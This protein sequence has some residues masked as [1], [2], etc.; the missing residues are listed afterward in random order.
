METILE[1]KD[2]VS[3]VNDKLGNSKHDALDIQNYINIAYYIGQQWIAIDPKNKQLYVPSKK[4]GE[5]RY[6]ANKVQPIVRT[7]L[8][9]LIKNKPICNVIPFSSEDDDIQAAHLG[10]KI[11]QAMDFQMDL[12]EAD[13]ELIM[14]G[15]CFG[16]SWVKPFWNGS[17]GVDLGGVHE[18]DI[19]KDIISPFELFWDNSAKKWS[20]V[21]WCCHQKTRTVDYVQEVYEKKVAPE[22][23]IS[24]SNI[25]D[26]KIQ[27][28][29]NVSGIEYKQ[30][31]NSVIVKEYWEKPTQKYPKG[32]RITIA[33]ETLLFYIEDIG[34][35]DEDRTERILPFFPFI[36]I[37][38]PGKVAGQSIIENL[39][40]VQRERNKSRS[41]IIKNK[42]LMAYPIWVAE[43]DTLENEII[44][45]AGEII[46]Y[47]EEAKNPPHIE[48]PPS[49]SSDVFESISQCDEE[50]Y[51]I[52]GQ[53]ETS[54]GALP[55]GQKLSG[56]GLSILQEQD[57][58]KLSPTV[59]NF[60]KCKSQYMSYILKIIKFKY[61]LERT[62]KF[63]GQTNQL[64]AVSFKGSDLT[65]TDV[66]VVAGS[67]L[68]QSKAAKQEYVMNLIDKGVLNPQ[69]DKQMI[70]NLLE[71]GITDNLYDDYSVDYNHAVGEVDKWKKGDPSP[72]V[73]DF[74]NHEAH[75]KV[76]DKFRKSDEYEQLPP[77]IQ[78]Y[79]D[80]HV[81]EHKQYIQQALMAAM[82]QVNN[83]NQPGTPQ[84]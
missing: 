61:E 30:E 51:F 13:K 45:D 57:D 43:K 42:D 38:V 71:L 10:E 15:L 76:H 34:F 66:K 12:G 25:F 19:D 23:G 9:K 41:Q 55:D 49:I 56:I 39:I 75:I 27:N 81:E 65:S 60:E 8:S 44:G 2:L 21:K 29:N 32:R 73:R 48:Q 6:T 78:Q 74:Y 54:H 24:S 53:G 80:A 16:I 33:N 72:M 7:E 1:D 64:E 35:G 63:V 5:I 67:A 52:S 28:L 69:Q 11:C 50:L 20:E 17:L 58:T 62:V 18:G 47:S 37:I 40:P 77:E 79:I 83:V 84:M 22:G 36:H 46:Y 59:Q 68:P 14:N 26:S 31:K 3:Y 82:P 70:L 4:P